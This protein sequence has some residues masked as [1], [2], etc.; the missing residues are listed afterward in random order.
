MCWNV[1]KKVLKIQHNR[2]Q[3]GSALHAKLFKEDEKNRCKDSATIFLTSRGGNTNFT[4]FNCN[5]FNSLFHNIA[6]VYMTCKDFYIHVL[7][8]ESRNRLLIS[9]SSSL[10]SELCISRCRALGLLDKLP[11]KPLWSILGAKDR[12]IQDMNIVILLWHTHWSAQITG[13]RK[14]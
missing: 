5:R 11:T 4:N 7:S 13:H 1:K 14:L 10:L 12:T 3:T 8:P 9:V 2:S 6:E